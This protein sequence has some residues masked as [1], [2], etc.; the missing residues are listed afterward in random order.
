M[1]HCA[2]A[3]GNGRSRCQS[4][5]RFHFD[6]VQT[7]L[8]TEKHA[9]RGANDLFGKTDFAEGAAGSSVMVSVIVLLIRFE[10]PAHI[11]VLG[12]LLILFE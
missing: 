11:V 1:A 5:C 6:G 4:L 9:H 7:S 8:G 3:G 10:Q 2:G 12:A